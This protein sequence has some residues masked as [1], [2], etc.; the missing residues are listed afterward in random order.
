VVFRSATKVARRDKRG[1]KKLLPLV[2]G[3]EQH[4]ADQADDGGPVGNDANDVGVALQIR[5]GV[6]PDVEDVRRTID[7][8]G[9]VM[10]VDLRD[11]G[12]LLLLATTG[13][14]NGELR[15]LQLQDIDWRAGE[16]F[17]RR[18]KGKRDRVAPLLDETGAALADYILQAR[19]KIDSP[20]LFLTSTPPVGPFKVE[21]YID[22][23]RSL[24][25]CK[26][27]RSAVMALSV[28]PRHASRKSLSLLGRPPGLPDWPGFHPGG[29]DLRGIV[30]PALRPGLAHVVR[31][32]ITIP[33]SGSLL[34]GVARLR[35]LV[36]PFPDKPSLRHVTM[37]RNDRLRGLL[38][39]TIESPH[40]VARPIVALVPSPYVHCQLPN[41]RSDR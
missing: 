41:L 27:S 13:I 28:A 22:L 34:L 29:G 24:G 21:R 11:R 40:D 10:P 20:Y 15:A 38:S 36:A 30:D 7:A 2:V 23:R 5:F 1:K 9:T 35:W 25:L 8:I 32:T 14:R 4:G 3:L 18:T 39:V 6:V 19:P 33:T 12:V 31:V 17:V 37:S 16:V 26:A